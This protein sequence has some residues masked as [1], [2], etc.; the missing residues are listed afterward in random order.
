MFIVTGGAGFIGSNVVK[1]LNARGQDDILIVDNLGSSMKFKNLNSL[2]Y[3]D[4]L[5]KDDFLTRLESGEYGH[6]RIE[7]I[8]HN[9]ACSATTESDGN[10]MMRNNY[11]YSKT[12]LHF[13]LDRKIPFIY[14][15]SASVYGNGENGFCETEECEKALNVYA[16]SK[17][18]FD[19]YVR[20]IL[21]QATSQ[22]VGLRYF[23]VFGPNEV[24][25]GR[26]AST[27]FHFFNQISE[28]GVA[29]LFGEYGGYGAGEQRRDFIYVK[30]VVNVNLFFADNPLISGIFNCGTGHARSFNDVVHAVAK[31]CNK[32]TIEY[33]PFPDDLKGK[34]QSYT[35][36]DAEKLLRAGYC[37]GF[38][39]LE[40]AAA[41]YMDYLKQQGGLL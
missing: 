24:H 28:S 13:A 16:F 22:I 17:L 1:G 11:E 33:I 21:P 19:R 14:A 12:L 34:Y 4:F 41:E 36:A 8:F 30:D 38:T 15:S 23:N 39:S 20:R 9:G 26:M 3:R 18:Q 40:A 25:K 6:E 2:R 5:H 37:D 7:G 27:L 35:Q 31:A 10:Y 29:R 32:G